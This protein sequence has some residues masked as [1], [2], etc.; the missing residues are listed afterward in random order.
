MKP[1]SGK[2]V[3]SDTLE[4]LE[5]TGGPCL[6]LLGTKEDK[7]SLKSIVLNLDLLLIFPVL[8][9]LPLPLPLD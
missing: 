4:I 6:P 8:M 2:F 5:H 7:V 9:M 3:L 1:N